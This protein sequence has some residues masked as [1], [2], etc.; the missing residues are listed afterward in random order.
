MLSASD[1]VLK[2]GKDIE[3]LDEEIAHLKETAEYN[4]NYGVVGGA[5]GA[6]V[7]IGIMIFVLRVGRS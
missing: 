6:L 5:L 7:M 2:T 1:S 3:A 4:L